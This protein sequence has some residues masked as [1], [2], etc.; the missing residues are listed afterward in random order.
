[1][2]QSKIY[3]SKR[4][5]NFA[6]KKLR[7]IFGLRGKVILKHTPEIHYYETKCF[8][9]CFSDSGKDNIPIH[10]IIMAEDINGNPKYY[11]STLLH[12]YVHAWQFENGYKGAHDKKS[13]FKAWAKYLK[14]TQK[15]VVI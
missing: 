2:S 3:P 14:E 10:R 11:M 6:A 13:K 5:K 8:G 4:V 12:E 1:M 7:R 9:L 15:G